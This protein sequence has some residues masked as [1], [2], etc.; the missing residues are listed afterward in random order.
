MVTTTPVDEKMKPTEPCVINGGLLPKD[1]TCPHPIIVI[2]VTSI[3]KHIKKIEAAAGKIIMHAL[4][5]GE[6][7]LYV[8]VSDPE[9][10][11]IGLW[12]TLGNC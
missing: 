12:K 8:M 2:D 3:E 5:V 4:K 9:N 7:G 1:S 10:N 11:V 6:F